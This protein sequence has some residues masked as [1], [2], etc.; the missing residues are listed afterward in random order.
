[1]E[2]ATRILIVDDDDEFCATLRDV[3]E[4]EG[5]TVTEAAHGEKA[6]TVLRNT[7][8]PHLIFLDLLMP[9][10]NGWQLYAELQR[11]PA[12]AVIP[13]AVLSAVADLRPE[14]FMHV[15]NKPVDLPNLLGLLHAV[16]A[17]GRPSSPVRLRPGKSKGRAGGP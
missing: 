1:M 13:V 7:A 11:E 6:L 8:L 3:L 14:G 4:L 16:Y 2:R 15:L 9:V 17:P 5:C 10:M 12:F